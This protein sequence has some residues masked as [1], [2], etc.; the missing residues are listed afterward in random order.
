MR[1]L[2]LLAF[3]VLGLAPGTWVRTHGPYPV[4]VG[5]VL[6]ITRLAAPARDIGRLRFLAAWQLE[7][8]NAQFGGY[9]ALVSLGDGRLLAASDR[10]RILILDRLETP[11]PTAVLDYFG[12]EEIEIKR[13]AD[14]EAL[15]RDPQTG[16]IWA[17][18][19]DSNQIAR[20]ETVA[21]G[22]LSDVRPPMMSRWRANSGPEAMVR[23]ADGRFLVLA[24]RGHRW[25]SESSP[26]LLFP[27][28]PVSGAAP[29]GFRFVRPSGYSPT[30]AVQLPSGEVLILL[31]TVDWLLPLRFS[32]KL[33]VADP[34]TIQA[35]GEW[36][37]RVVA[38]IARPLPSDNF[39]GLAIEPEPGGGAVLWVISDDNLAPA[40]RTLLLKLH[41]PGA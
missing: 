23:L 13:R 20:I 17:A 41:W 3:V 27:D 21:G 38:D 40:Q 28:D 19:E 5:R 24:E 31:R 2:V 7:S 1:R 11:H 6:K 14:I 34:A 39:E 16:R 12:G 33:A 32:A 36:R 9:S 30:D 15:T 18:Y 37:A 35:G 10:G 8:P 4:E 26:G 29:I 25:S 22:G